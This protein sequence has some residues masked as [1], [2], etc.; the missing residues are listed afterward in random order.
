MKLRSENRFERRL[1]TTRV[2]RHVCYGSGGGSSAPSSTTTTTSN[3]P[4]YLQPYVERNIGAAEGIAGQAYTPYGGQR[5]AEFNPNQMGTQA[6]VMGMQTPGQFVPAGAATANVMGASWADPRVSAAFMNPYQQNV[7]DIAK[8]EAARQS[9]IQGTQ[10]G[11]QFAKAGA[12]G[13]SRQGIAEAERQRNLAQQMGDIQ[14]QGSNQ[15][16]QQGM[17]QFNVQQQQRLAA[18]QQLAG[19]GTQQQQADLA[20]FGAQ[21]GVGGQQ[22]ALEQQKMSQAYQDFIN[23]RDYGKQQAGWM[24]SM[25]HG[26]PAPTDTSTQTYTPPPNVAGQVAG[27][28]IA[29][30]GAYNAANK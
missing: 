29:G 5:I 9:D 17:G 27:L 3:L 26:T 1:E 4:S 28:G 15:A 16:Y 20:R 8:R 12:F 7:T 6:N 19:L 25:L 2:G 10:S 18:A 21:A 24:S 11:A 23:Q 30:V 14:M 13:G 22:Q